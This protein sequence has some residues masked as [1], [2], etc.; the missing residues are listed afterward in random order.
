MGMESLWCV[1]SVV[2]MLVFL[3]YFQAFSG[4]VDS[5]PIKIE[6]IEI[7]PDPPLPG[8]N[9]TVAVTGT[10]NQVI[11]VSRD[12]IAHNSHH[13]NL[14]NFNFIRRAHT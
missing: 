1:F 11:E 10:A 8:K 13:R 12:T 2:L 14:S 9:L 6:S 7:F 5:D 3:S 4:N